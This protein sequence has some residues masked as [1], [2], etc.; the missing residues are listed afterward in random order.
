MIVTDGVICDMGETVDAI[1]KATDSAL[2]IIIVGV[3]RADFTSM[4]KLDGD[5]GLPLRSRS[6]Q[7]AK[8]DIV[9]FV[10]VGKFENKYPALAAEVL[11]EIPTQVHAFCSA[12]GFVPP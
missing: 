7:R 3:R 11:A 9:Q 4:S 12:Q 6:G 5:D 8:R 2:S 10:P 1:V